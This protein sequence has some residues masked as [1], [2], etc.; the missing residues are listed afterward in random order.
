[1]AAERF[2]NPE[3]E[4]DDE[5]RNDIKKYVMQNLKREEVLDFLRRDYPQ[6]MWSLPTLSRRMCT[7]GIKYVDYNTNLEDVRD[8]VRTEIDGP[9][10]LL[11]YR[12]LQRKLREQHD[13]AVPRSLVYNVMTDE[14]PEGLEAR[15]NVGLG[16]KKKRGPTGTFTSLVIVISFYCSLF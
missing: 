10:K 6:Y 16:R 13:L 1:M 15:A 8:A 11:G 14:Y 12:M 4:E 2:Q 7:F 9:G 3:W 5:L